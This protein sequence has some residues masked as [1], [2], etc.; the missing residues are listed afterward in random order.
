MNE[1][2][3]I[4]NIE[5]DKISSLF[6]SRCKTLVDKNSKKCDNLKCSRVFCSECINTIKCPE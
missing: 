1:I 6:C 3:S 2:C 4:K 5:I